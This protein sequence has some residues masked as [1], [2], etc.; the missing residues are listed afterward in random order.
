MSIQAVLLPLFVLVALTFALH[1]WMGFARVSS[2][3]RGEVK[4]GDIA[5]REPNWPV[6]VTQIANAFHNQL[7]LPVLFY[8]LVGL[9][10]I[11]RKADLLFVVMSWLFVALRFVHAYIFVTSNRVLRRFQAFAAGSLVL[12]LMWIIFAVRVLLGA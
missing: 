11:A 4:T 6:R 8:V 2:L 1:Y 10:L 12:F 9:A 3:R 7:E 5:L